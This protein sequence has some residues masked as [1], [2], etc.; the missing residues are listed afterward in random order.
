[1]ISFCI[2]SAPGLSFNLAAPG[3]VMTITGKDDGLRF[4]TLETERFAAR[5]IARS[6][7]EKSIRLILCEATGP[8]E[9][10]GDFRVGPFYLEGDFRFT[11]RVNGSRAANEEWAWWVRESRNP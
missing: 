5:I 3:G 11:E 6:H 8:D 1:M 10:G 7:G 9:V 2:G 4:G